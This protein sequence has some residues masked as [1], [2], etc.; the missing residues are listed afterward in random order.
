V[1]RRPGLRG[2]GAKSR[3]NITLPK[4]LLE[5]VDRLVDAEDEAWSLR[6]G[7]ASS[8]GRSD[9]LEMF[10]EWAI[11]EWY[12]RYGELPQKSDPRRREFIRGLAEQHLAE[13]RDDLL[14]EVNKKG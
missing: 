11:P 13:L 2:R 1:S 5:E 8:Y 3:L 9:L 6:G 12:S 7:S 4:H 14:R 10:I